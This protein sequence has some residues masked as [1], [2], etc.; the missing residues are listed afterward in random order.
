L[1]EHNDAV[2]VSSGHLMLALGI[3]TPIIPSTDTYV[4][5]VR[6]GILS[7]NFASY[8]LSA[9]LCIGYRST[10]YSIFFEQH[11]GMTHYFGDKFGT[12]FYGAEYSNF[13]NKNDKSSY[14]AS[15][16]NG[17]VIIPISKNMR[18]PLK[19]GVGV[20]YGKYLTV[21]VPTQL[22]K[23]NY[24]AMFSMKF[25]VDFEYLWR[26]DKFALTLNMGVAYALGVL[27]HTKET[28]ATKVFH[29]IVPQISFG[30]LY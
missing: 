24:H 16:I 5:N 21:P 8:A 27:K 9:Q 1:L 22:S 20:I 11:L 25:G 30:F 18:I 3:I 23:E 15:Y 13:Y 19:M 28:D 29:Y 17:S 6:Y 26:I 10:Y 4:D 14:M 7:V 2:D 12:V